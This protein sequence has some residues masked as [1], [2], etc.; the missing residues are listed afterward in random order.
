MVTSSSVLPA[1]LA[2]GLFST[3]VHGVTVATSMIT[4]TAVFRQMNTTM[5]VHDQLC[6]TY[7]HHVYINAVCEPLQR[8][9]LY[10]LRENHLMNLLLCEGLLGYCLR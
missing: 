4:S 7:V 6:Q 9:T 1:C 5:C 10:Q 3:I 2:A 8:G